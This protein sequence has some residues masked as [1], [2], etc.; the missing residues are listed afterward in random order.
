M[1]GRMAYNTPW[2]IAAVDKAFYGST[3]DT[4]NR[5]EVM[6]EYAEFVEK[7]QLEAISN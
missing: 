2:Q 6:M 7:E 3:E 4:R 5:A 1:V